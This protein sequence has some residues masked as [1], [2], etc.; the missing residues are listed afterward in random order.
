[1]NFCIPSVL[2][3]LLLFFNNNIP[4]S[5]TVLTTDGAHIHL[6]RWEL[7]QGR[8]FASAEFHIYTRRA[9]SY[10]R[11]HRHTSYLTIV[12]HQACRYEKISLIPR[13]CTSFEF[14]IFTRFRA[15]WLVSHINGHKVL[16][17]EQMRQVGENNPRQQFCFYSGYYF[18]RN[19][20]SISCYV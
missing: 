10:A 16:L 9:Y 4:P 13:L 15:R 8:H 17:L 1:M 14:R 18:M 20:L 7:T 3:Y 12:M 11:A 5:A 6:F 2:F 19:Y